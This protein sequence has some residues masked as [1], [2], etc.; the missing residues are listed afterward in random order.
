MFRRFR[1]GVSGFST[2]LL[3]ELRKN[4]DIVILGPNKGNGVVVMDKNAYEQG[5]FAIISDMSNL[6]AMDNNPTLQ[7]AN[8]NVL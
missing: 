1:F 5:I 6:K 7:R 8:C 2:C 3:K 4:K